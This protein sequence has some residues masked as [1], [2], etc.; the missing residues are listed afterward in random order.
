MSFA[1]F[2][3]VVGKVPQISLVSGRSAGRLSNIH[4]AYSAGE[5][6]LPRH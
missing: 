3:P 5:R 2:F 4:A 1:E 6:A